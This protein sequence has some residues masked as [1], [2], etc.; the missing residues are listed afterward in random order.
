MSAVGLLSSNL[1]SMLGEKEVTLNFYL[2]HLF[3]LLGIYMLLKKAVEPFCERKEFLIARA[4]YAQFLSE[5]E[6]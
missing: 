3:A 4:H 2:F 1:L 6:A 5:E